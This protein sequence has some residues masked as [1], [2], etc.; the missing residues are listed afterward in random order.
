MKPDQAKAFRLICDQLIREEDPIQFRF[1]HAVLEELFD[2][3][4]RGL[5]DAPSR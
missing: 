3:V 4:R 1:Y 5:P 2:E